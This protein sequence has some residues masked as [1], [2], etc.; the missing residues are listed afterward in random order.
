MP[1][2]GVTTPDD[3]LGRLWIK[4]FISHEIL[5]FAWSV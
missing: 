1:P 3:D 2:K 4:V 5:D